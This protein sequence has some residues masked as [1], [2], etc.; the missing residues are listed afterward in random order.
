MLIW[1][2]VREPEALQKVQSLIIEMEQGDRSIW[3]NITSYKIFLSVLKKSEL[4]ED[5]KRR[6]IDYVE[7]RIEELR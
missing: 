4:A 2:N 7:N 1:S 5:E 3:P 6:R